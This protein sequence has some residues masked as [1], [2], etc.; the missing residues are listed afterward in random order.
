MSAWFSCGLISISA[1]QLF[2]H[3]QNAVAPAE[4][5]PVEEVP[6]ETK[7]VRRGTV[8][9]EPLAETEW[10]YHKSKDGTRPSG[11][12]Q[13]YVWL[14]NRARA[15]PS[16]EGKWLGWLRETD[17]RDAVDY[18]RVNRAL[19]REELTAL[20]AAPPAAFD[21]RLH[22]A[23]LRHSQRLAAEDAQHHN[24]QFDE[25]TAAGFAYTSLSGSVYSY[26]Q[27]GLHGHA[28][29][30]IDWG[31]ND[32]SGM[33]TGRGH[34]A[35][36]M[37][38]R[39]HVGVAVL[40]ENDSATRVG[41]QVTTINYATANANQP[42][43]SNRFIVGTVWRDANRNRLYDPGEGIGGVMVKPD[44]GTFFAITGEAGGYA[45]PVEPGTYVLTFSGGGLEPPQS[46]TVVVGE[47]SV[48]VPWEDASPWL[49]TPQLTVE[50]SLRV[51][52]DWGF[53]LGQ[54]STVFVSD[55]LQEWLP[56]ETGLI[57]KAGRLSWTGPV[58]Q[59]A[60]R[61]YWRIEAWPY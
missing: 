50:S 9:H 1:G 5:P 58:D 10:T 14:M 57:D 33:Q 23:A 24:G 18:F 13:Q 46:R 39:S 27:S 53:A 38:V 49:E 56:V 19:L 22:E 54:P 31:G 52:A 44:Q 26:A 25:I 16:T 3:D 45:F 2:S 37:S 20:S 61:R 6:P 43:H 40:L 36:L 59:G 30:N 12:E 11:V 60:T 17:V 7:R 29:F 47:V 51:N 28:A 48:L 21:I 8:P 35:G 41:P 55:D 15:N 4:N 34:R 42:Q 32:G